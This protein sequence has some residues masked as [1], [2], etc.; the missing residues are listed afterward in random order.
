MGVPSGANSQPPCSS[1]LCGPV[2]K[3]KFSDDRGDFLAL[4]SFAAYSWNRI[5]CPPRLGLPCVG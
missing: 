4:I 3:Y 5:L 1:K 2:P